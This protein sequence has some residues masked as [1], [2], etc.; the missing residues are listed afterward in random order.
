M[1]HQVSEKGD[2]IALFQK[3]H[4]KAM[5]KRVRIYDGRIDPIFAGQ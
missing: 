1:A 4:C 5:A 2:V 3:V